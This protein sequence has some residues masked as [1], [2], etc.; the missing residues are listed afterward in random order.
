MMLCAAV[1]STRKVLMLPLNVPD[2]AK[3]ASTLSVPPLPLMVPALPKYPVV[4]A[5]PPKL[6][7]PL[8]CSVELKSMLPEF[9][10]MLP[11]ED[12]AAE[13]VRRPV[14]DVTTVPAPSDVA[15]VTVSA[16][17]AEESVPPLTDV[18]VPEIVGADVTKV[19]VPLPFVDEKLLN[20]T[21]V[22][23]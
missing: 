18:S 10:P 17:A 15:P 7:V 5:D 23:F 9:E 19:A 13:K 11:V 14:V 4:V 3:S 22:M 12:A 2:E 1:P 6:N 16:N 20:V 21:P 8:F